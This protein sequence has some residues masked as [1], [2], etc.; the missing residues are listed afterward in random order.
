MTW[1]RAE[2]HLS[3]SDLDGASLALYINDLGKGFA[4]VNGNALGR[5]DHLFFSS[6][7]SDPASGT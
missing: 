1:Y 2:F 7:H 4:W 6:T 5:C 3:K